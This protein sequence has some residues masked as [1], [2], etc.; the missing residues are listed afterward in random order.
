VGLAVSAFVWKLIDALR[1]RAVDDAAWRGDG[2]VDA[3][4][5]EERAPEEG[6]RG[7]E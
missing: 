3:Y 1:E 6:G 2:Y 7:G 4:A 5:D